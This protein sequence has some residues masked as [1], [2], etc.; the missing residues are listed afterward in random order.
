MCE[1]FGDKSF[2]VISWLVQNT[3]VAF[4]TNHLTDNVKAKHNYNEE[5]H[6]NLY[7]YAM[8]LLPYELTKANKTEVWFRIFTLSSQYTKW[9]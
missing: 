3:W 1:C 8:E 5:Q 7:K 6:N 2:Q 9:L 4:S